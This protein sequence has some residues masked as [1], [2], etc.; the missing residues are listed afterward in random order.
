MID[1]ISYRE[2]IY[3]YVNRE[4]GSKIEYLWMKYPNYAVFRNNVNQ[5]WYGIIMDIPY[6]KL[7][8]DS[9][10]IVDVLNV[11]VADYILKNFL[12][13]QD[14]F[15][16]AYHMASGNWVSILLDGTVDL[17]QILGLI[18]ESYRIV[19]SSNTK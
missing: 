12:I 17:K 6:K 2:Q 14:G 15:F 9:D 16:D 7:G 10:G 18:D 19:G 11:K 13:Q 5:K 8:F 3:E 4:Y 1:T